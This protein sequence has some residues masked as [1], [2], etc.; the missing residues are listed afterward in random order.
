MTTESVNRVLGTY[1]DLTREG[2]PIC[3]VIAL[4]DGRVILAN[5]SART[6]SGEEPPT[7]EIPDLTATMW[8]RIVAEATGSARTR[9][10][11]P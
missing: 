5:A 11:A 6:P 10:N 1:T 7:V 9:H 4:N 2:S 8:E 3:Y